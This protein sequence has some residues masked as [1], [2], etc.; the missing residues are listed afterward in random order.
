M[1]TANPSPTPS[2]D[3]AQRLILAP[4]LILVA[5][6]PLPLG[7]FRPLAWSFY[8]IA[9]A[10]LLVVWGAVM[11]R[12]DARPPVGPGRL[13]VPLLLGLGVAGWMA[14][15]ALVALPAPWG[16]P[17]WAEAAALLPELGG[18]APVSVNP[19]GGV[20]GL[21]RFLTHGAIFLLAVQ[22]GRSRRRAERIFATLAYVGLGYALYGLL[23]HL[24]G[25]NAV[26]WWERWA[27]TD[28]VTST[29]V[30]RNHYATYAGLTLLCALGL[31]GRS[32]LRR[33]NPVDLKELALLFGE[34]LERRWPL[35]LGACVIFSA[36][37]LS[38]S[39]AGLAATVAAIVVLLLVLPRGGWSERRMA[40]PMLAAAT[41]G[42][43]LLLFAMGGE[44]LGRAG[45]W[46]FQSETR[47]HL[48]ELTLRA[49]GD[50][51]WLGHGGGGFA[52]V[53]RLYRDPL[54]PDGYQWGHAHNS[55][56]EFALEY[57]LFALLVLLALFAWLVGRLALG[58]VQRR[59]DRL[60]AAVGIA[61]SVLVGLHALVD[62]SVQLP[63]VAIPFAAILGVAY[64]QSWPSRRGKR[65]SRA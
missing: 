24:G 11:L 9:A 47:V 14:F 52:D 29:F 12:D 32:L 65:D 27:Y 61:A 55:Y 53:I 22:L 19:P 23:M 38:H 30:N 44:T 51:P 20:E 8:A 50:A 6:A 21:L 60:Y 1:T 10:L 33:G 62:F 49:I 54:L 28:S 4:F 63:G 31:L 18:E 41:V 58:L 2:E 48:F 3:R 7:G 42:F 5:V 46:S 26:L 64:A 57:G 13:A 35:L 39:R 34:L 45:D 37:G 17:L 59:R 16:A 36:L 43:L 40:R 15:Q 56:L 25:F